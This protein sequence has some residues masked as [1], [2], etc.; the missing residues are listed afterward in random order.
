MKKLRSESGITLVELLAALVIGS[1]IIILTISL[2][3]A[4]HKQYG[5]QSDEIRDLMNVSTAAQAIT[6]DIRSAIDIDVNTAEKSITINKPDETIT[7]KL[8]D[9][10]LE[11]N[12]Q[13]YLYDI[14][15]FFVKLIEE[16][17]TVNLKIHGSANQKV[18]TSIAIRK[19]GEES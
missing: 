6:K 2:F 16:S 13:I 18:E 17:Q 8:V 9:G 4:F 1:I 12:N 19:G 3:M 11:K 15:E 7:Y 14:D 10:H 5:K